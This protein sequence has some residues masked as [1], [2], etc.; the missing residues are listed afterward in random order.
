MADTNPNMAE[1]TLRRHRLTPAARA[2]VREV[3]VSAEQFI[4]PHFVVE[5]LAEREPV[6]GMPGVHRETVATLLQQ[7]AADLAKGVNRII[8]F[9]VPATKA[10]RDFD[11][12]FTAA[13]IETIKQQFGEQLWVAVD[14]CVCSHTVHGQCGVVNDAGDHVDNAA[15]VNELARAA[16]VYAEAGADCV[17]PSD[18]MDGRVGAIRSMLDEHGFAERTLM[19]YSAKFHSGFYGPFRG[20]ADSAPKPGSEISLKDRASYQ[21]DPTHPADALQ[22]SERDLKE[23]A[24]ILMVK[25]GMPYLDVLARLTAALPQVPWAV[26]EVSGEYAA[27]EVLAAE[28]LID[29]ERAHVEVWVAFVRA[30]ATHIISYGARHAAEWLAAWDERE[31]QQ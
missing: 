12:S 31:Q 30:G 13:V 6:K 24:D 2:A 29:R 5:G 9:G 28:Q 23:G 16:L 20:A 11:F 22:S 1:L 3:F 10:E 27:I 25:P 17:A 14:V 4:Q 26:Y 7:L 18:M 15:T 21:I 8:L 19:S